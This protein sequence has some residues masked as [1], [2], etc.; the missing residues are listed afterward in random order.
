MMAAF[1]GKMKKNA[2]K[3]QKKCILHLEIASKIYY[4]K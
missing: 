1:E 4:D 3:I 2:S